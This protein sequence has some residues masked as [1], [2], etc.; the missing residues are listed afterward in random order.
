MFWHACAT[1]C[2]DGWPF[3]LFVG[4]WN[5]LRKI[6]C[7]ESVPTQ[8][9]FKVDLSSADNEVTFCQHAFRSHTE[10]AMKSN[11]GVVG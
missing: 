8:Y 1:C 10:S 4:V 11:W 9:K 7:G 5:Y 6:V 2:L 3:S